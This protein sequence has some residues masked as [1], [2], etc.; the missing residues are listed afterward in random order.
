MLI[1]HQKIS[2]SVGE[3]VQ[4]ARRRYPELTESIPTEILNRRQDS[5]FQNLKYCYSLQS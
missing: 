3:G 2:G 4:S 1:P 5:G